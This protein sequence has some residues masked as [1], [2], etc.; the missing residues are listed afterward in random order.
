MYILDSSFFFGGKPLVLDGELWTTDSVR[1]EIKDFS[2]RARL[3]ILEDNGLKIG[4]ASSEDIRKVTAAAEASGD[5]R[6]L[7]STDI[8]VIALGL[9]LQGTVVS[10]DFAVQNVCKHLNIPVRSLLAK[11]AKKKIWKRICS[12]CGAEIPDGEAE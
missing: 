4:Q 8:S 11:T 5:L 12:G 6:V 9:S 3:Q 2:S 1:E 10:A 7:S